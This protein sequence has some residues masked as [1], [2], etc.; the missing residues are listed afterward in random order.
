M[1]DRTAGARSPREGPTPSLE[2]LSREQHRILAY[3]SAV[4]SEFGFLLLVGALRMDEERLAEELERLVHLGSIAERTGG[5]LFTFTNEEF[6]ARLYR[7]LTESRVRVIHRKIAE[8]LEK[9][10]PEPPLPVLAELGRHCFLGKVRAKSYEYNR[11]AAEGARAAGMP[12]IAVGHLERVLLDLASLPGDHRNERA[13]VAEAL[14]DLWYSLSNFRKADQR[15]TQALEQLGAGSPRVRARLSLS[16][17][18]VAREDLDFATSVTH[19]MEALRLF[20]EVGDRLG[21]AQAHRLLGRVAWLRGA[22]RES[23]EECQK[24][25]DLVGTTADPRLLGSLSIDLG[26]ASASLHPERSDV[27]IA[28]Y[29]RAVEQLQ[30]AGDWFELSRAYHNLGEEVGEVRP[31]DAL[32]YL[33]KAQQAAARSHDNRGV[34]RALL[35]RV[36]L[37]LAL[38]QVGDAELDN[39]QA[40]RMLRHISDELGRAWVRL[41]RGLIAERRG[42]W[43]DAERAFEQA[44]ETAQRLQ[45][46]PEE[47]EAAFYLARLRF[48][49]RDLEGARHA[50]TIASDL[51]LAALQPQLASQFRDLGR[52]LGLPRP[53]LPGEPAPIHPGPAESDGKRG[54]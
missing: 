40:D 18:E 15:F 51:G 5:E 17:A 4:G 38:G 8:A 7:S 52:Q 13:E 20:E 32:E 26:N 45:L 1:A 19:S 27:A 30:R 9:M 37:H 48:K 33:E 11:R 6:R 47:A 3:A 50:Y 2:S 54:S 29:G 16:R 44:I 22:Y 41:H 43:E 53:V 34:A 36:E 21:V 24:A 35:S 39:E 10:Y 46:P 12:E 28:W 14:G 42:L 31:Q 23:L 49:V 25:L